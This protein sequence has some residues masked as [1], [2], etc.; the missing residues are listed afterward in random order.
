MRIVNV[1]VP[2]VHTTI[3]KLP[4]LPG[5]VE[6]ELENGA[7][8]NVKVEWEELAKEQV[9]IPGEIEVTGKI[10]SRE[11]P[12]PLIEQRADP[13]IL[14]HTDGYYYF[15]G[16][17]PL[18]DR[19]VLRR[20]KTISELPAAEEVVIW[21]K[22]ESGTMSEH[23][24]APE[25]HYINKKWYI[26]FAAGERDDVWAIRPYVLECEDENPLTGKWIEKGQV[27]TNFQSFSLD[28]TTFEHNGIRYLIWAQKVNNDTISNLYI[29]KMSNPWTIEGKQV[30]LSTPEYEWEYQGFYVNEGPAVIKRNGYIF[31]A[32]SA[33]ATDDR[34]AVGLLSAKED[35]D[36]LNPASW[37]KSKEP[38]FVT[39]EET[40][41]YGPGHNSFTV[42]EDGSSDLI[43]Y[44]ARPYK[45]IVGNSLYDYNR[46]ARVQ[47]IFWN[48][49][50]TP[51]FGI[52][53]YSLEDGDIKIYAKINIK[54]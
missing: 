39:S 13:Y 53:G 28:A 8:G 16:S 48:S 5:A 50:G 17:Y 19:I 2:V 6:V 38:V 30:L 31:V 14:K 23:I 11:Y 42:T 29:A 22:H 49:D 21:K 34:Y 54:Q 4:K 47:R 44:H 26:Y 27:N 18:Y 41:Q 46:H 15:T 36:L 35:N 7:K 45:E 40:K 37:T 43:V 33:S 25:L 51:Y 32:Y 12:D 9:S 52:P 3:G 10:I 24:W 1:S 20:A